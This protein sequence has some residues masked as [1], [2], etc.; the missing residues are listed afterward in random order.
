[1]SRKMEKQQT[2]P[3]EAGRKPRPKAAARPSGAERSPGEHRRYTHSQTISQKRLSR[4]EV[5][6]GIA[7]T[8]A[9]DD[10]ADVERP[11]SRGQCRGAQRPC[12]WA[13]CRYHL[14]V[15]VN[16]RTGSLKLNFPEVELE[17]MP[18]TCVLDVAERGGATLDAIGKLMNLTR[19]RVRQVQLAA[20]AKL[21]TISRGEGFQELPFGD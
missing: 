13:G 14:Y 21:R 18:E 10:R 11:Q 12:P 6:L 16:Q 5:R 2:E 1:M 15:D 3:G 4:E 9:G 20:L 7:L 17:E 19:E 8:L